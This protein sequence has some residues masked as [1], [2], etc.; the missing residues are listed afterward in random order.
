MCSLIMVH[1][2]PFM[3]Q[4]RKNGNGIMLKKIQNITLISTTI[5]HLI[6]QSNW[7]NKKYDV[8]LD[9]QGAELVVLNG[10]GKDM[11]LA[12]EDQYK[13]IGFNKNMIVWTVPSRNTMPPPKLT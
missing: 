1:H 10:F 12:F 5:E 13:P 7:N 3:N 2:H 4:I 6:K 8:I 9:V 11:Q